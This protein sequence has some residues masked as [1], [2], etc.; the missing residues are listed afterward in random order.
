MR[1]EDQLVLR[2][3]MRRKSLLDSFLEQLATSSDTPWFRKNAAMF[4]EVCDAHGA[5]A[6]Q[7][8]EKLVHKFIEEPAIDTGIEDRD[9]L[10]ASGPPLPVMLKS[11]RKLADLRAAAERDDIPSRYRDMRAIRVALG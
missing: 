10:T 11:L 6:T 2:D 3:C 9:G 8:H 1:P 5:T 4:L 7:H